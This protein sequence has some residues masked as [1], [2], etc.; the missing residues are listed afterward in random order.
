MKFFGLT[1]VALTFSVGAFASTILIPCG[2]ATAPTGNL[3]GGWSESNGSNGYAASGTQPTTGSEVCPAF[4]TASLA[5]STITAEQLVVQSDYTGGSLGITN[6]ISNSYS[7]TP[8]A[9]LIT[10]IMTATSA[11]GT[12]PSENYTD[13]IGTLYNGNS[14]FADPTFGTGTFA[15]FSVGYNPTVTAGTVQ[16]VSGQLYELI[17]YQSSAPEPGSMMLLGGGLL[18]AGLI[19]R[20]KLASRK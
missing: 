7:Y 4:S 16:G 18:A 6:S 15:A 9:T 5:G 20:K 19:G 17:T 3:S 13:N 12:G 11:P 14:Y 1:A 8:Y 2:G 10:D